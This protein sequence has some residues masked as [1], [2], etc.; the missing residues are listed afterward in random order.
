[1]Q[2]PSKGS[3]P[4]GYGLCMQTMNFGRTVF[5]VIPPHCKNCISSGTAASKSTVMITKL[6]ILPYSRV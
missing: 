6:Q 3:F 4:A 2:E 1:M 5:S